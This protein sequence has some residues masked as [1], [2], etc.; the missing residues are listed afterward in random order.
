MNLEM[1]QAEERFCH[2]SVFRL[3]VE[4]VALGVAQGLPLVPR[5]VAVRTRMG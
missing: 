1:L 3:R 4:Q 5:Y 2:V